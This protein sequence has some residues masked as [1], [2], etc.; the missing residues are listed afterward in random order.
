MRQ[1]RLLCQLRVKNDG[2]PRQAR[3]ERK[4]TTQTEGVSNSMVELAEE[5]VVV[6][7]YDRLAFGWYGP[8]GPYGERD[9]VFAIRV[10]V[11][12]P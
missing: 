7:S 10:K 2:L 12:Q 8:P 6:V 3:D 4:E 5:N 9:F 1:K 11:G